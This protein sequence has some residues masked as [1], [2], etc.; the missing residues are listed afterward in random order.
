MEGFP[1]F[2]CAFSILIVPLIGIKYL[3]FVLMGYCAV[4]CIILSAAIF[5][6]RIE[7]IKKVPS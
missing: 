1:L 3:H 7:N 2:V 4:A 5:M 6:D